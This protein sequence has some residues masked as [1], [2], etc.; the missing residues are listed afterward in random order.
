MCD[1]QASYV[2]AEGAQDVRNLGNL[3]GLTQFQ[4]FLRAPAA[5]SVQPKNLS[6]IARDAGAAANKANVRIS[7]V[8]T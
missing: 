3:G 8:V 4:V 1:W 5:R 7:M 2:Q 6:A